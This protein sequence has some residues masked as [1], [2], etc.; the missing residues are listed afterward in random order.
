M[1][2]KRDIYWIW[3]IKQDP[4]WV[5]GTQKTLE[6]REDSM[7]S[8]FLQKSF[9]SSLKGW[10]GSLCS[11]SESHIYLSGWLK[12]SRGSMTSGTP[13]WRCI[14]NSIR[15]TLGWAG[16][17]TGFSVTSLLLLHFLFFLL[18]GHSRTS[19]NTKAASLVEHGCLVKCLRKYQCWDSSSANQNTCLLDFTGK[20]KVCWISWCLTSTRLKTKTNSTEKTAWTL[21]F[22]AVE[23]S[24]GTW[25]S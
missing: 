3:Y 2:D 25:F 13:T 5:L 11:V 6:D 7:V 1:C 14:N 23:S 24:E 22:T 8:S 15:K 16:T 12:S 19:L 18:F 9:S 20:V 21:T 10:R 17:G 4:S